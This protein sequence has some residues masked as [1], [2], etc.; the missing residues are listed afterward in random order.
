MIIYN[1]QSVLEVFDFLDLE[2][3]IFFANL[4]LI[5]IVL[6]VTLFAVIKVSSFYLSNWQQVKL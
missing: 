3:I 6:L 5:P 2:I 1:S 4:P